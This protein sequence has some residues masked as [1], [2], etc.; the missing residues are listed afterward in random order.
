[1]SAVVYIVHFYNFLGAPVAEG[2]GTKFFELV[3]G[4]ALKFLEDIAS[5]LNASPF[6]TELA[7]TDGVTGELFEMMREFACDLVAI[8][9]SAFRRHIVD[10]CCSKPWDWLI[11]VAAETSAAISVRCT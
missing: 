7:A 9:T 8:Y 4:R 10:V 3:C 2:G 11:T 5:P 1:M 6:W